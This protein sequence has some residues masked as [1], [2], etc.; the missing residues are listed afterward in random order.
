MQPLFEIHHVCPGIEKKWIYFVNPQS[1]GIVGKTA[2][3]ESRSEMPN[4]FVRII[5]P[6]C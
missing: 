2:M 3:Q 4:I 5:E 6:S 1:F